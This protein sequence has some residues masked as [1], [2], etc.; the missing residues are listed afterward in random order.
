MFFDFEKP[1][2]ELNEQ[3][4]K[5]KETHAK[6]KINMTDTIDSLTQKINETKKNIY[7]NEH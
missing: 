5:A 6:G 2:Q 1:I 3:L 4:E 7:S